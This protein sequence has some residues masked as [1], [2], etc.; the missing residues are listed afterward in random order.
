MRRKAE[1]MGHDAG[2]VWVS[3][4][5]LQLHS[6]SGAF[7]EAFS[8]NRGRIVPNLIWNLEGKNAGVV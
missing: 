8:R 5:Q 3:L 4:A 2:P 1:R 7:L 6:D